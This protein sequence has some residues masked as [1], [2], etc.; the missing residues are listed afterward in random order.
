MKLV[1][2]NK[3]NWKEI[4]KIVLIVNAVDFDYSEKLANMLSYEL[5]PNKCH[6]FVP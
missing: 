6:N 3:E 2:S 1:D 4:N 5:L